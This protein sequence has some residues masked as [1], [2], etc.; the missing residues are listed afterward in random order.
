MFL[1]MKILCEVKCDYITL[2]CICN[3]SLKSSSIF[4]FFCC[5]EV[6]PFSLPNLLYYYH[7]AI[8]KLQCLCYMYISRLLFLPSWFHTLLV[9]FPFQD[10]FFSQ[11]I[12]LHLPTPLYYSCFPTV[13]C[14]FS[15][16]N[17]PSG[18]VTLILSISFYKNLH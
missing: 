15:K 6:F 7:H 16:S 3:I 14:L 18:N 12:C 10:L 13:C 8:F 5:S 11:Y 4:F 1:N 17:F 9:S 2:K